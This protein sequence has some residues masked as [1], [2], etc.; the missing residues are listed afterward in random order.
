MAQNG[1][2]VAGKKVELIVKDDCV[3]GA[4]IK[5]PTGFKKIKATC[6]VVLAT[7][8]AAHCSEL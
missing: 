2:M 7:G 6:G 1:D 5:T 4:L 3:I 8:G